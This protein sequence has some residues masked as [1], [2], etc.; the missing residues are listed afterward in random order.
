[1]RR[2]R[3][4]LVAT[5]VVLL[6]PGFPA[7]PEPARDPYA[8]VR[9]MTISCPGAGRIWGSD[10]M[11]D[12]MRDLKGLGVNWITIHPY[13]A[14]GADGTV[15]GGRLA[16]MYATPSWLTRPIEEAHRLG[17]K[18]MIKPHIAYWGSPFSWRGAI[19]FETDA[20][21]RRFFESYEDWITLVARL[22]RE[23]D[24]F[25]VGT[26][27]DRT[28]HHEG[29][30]RRIVRAVR[31]SIRA[32]LTYSA[33]WDR[34]EQVPFWDALDAIGIQAYF[35]LVEHEGLPSQQELDEA[36]T[37]LVGRLER[38]AAAHDRDIVFGELGYNESSLAAVRPWEYRQGGEHAEETQRR[39]LT[40]AMKAIEGSDTVAGAFLWKWF[41]G[42]S[43]RGRRNFLKSTPS[44]RA[45]IA[46]YWAE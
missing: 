37:R 13:A 14:I 9:G 2:V 21:W 11:V 18:I 30:W 16:Q 34:F 19:T 32:P 44:M 39:C 29:A 40:A 25:V 1:M 45:V 23:A 17:L 36:W 7:V 41:P 43:T 4:S 6:A 35:P 27:L 12:A 38:F 5:A 46:R 31:G 15:G 24:A 20:Q 8:I 3:A 22:S 28:V 10:L 26:E 42:Q 33:G